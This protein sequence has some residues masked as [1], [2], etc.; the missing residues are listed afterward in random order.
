MDPVKDAKLKFL[1]RHLQKTQPATTNKSKR[2]VTVEEEHTADEE[3]DRRSVFER[4]GPGSS[5][6]VVCLLFLLFACV[7]LSLSVF[8]SY[9]PIYVYQRFDV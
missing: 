6:E 3:S 1:P 4:L 9:F 5:R 7:C 2:R 8:F